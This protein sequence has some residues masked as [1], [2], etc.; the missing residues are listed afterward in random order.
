MFKA[1]I[2]ADIVHS[3]KLSNADRVYLLG[4]LSKE[5]NRLDKK[6][7]AKSELYRGDSIQ[8]VVFDVW[9]ALR[10][11]LLIKFF[12]RSLSPAERVKIVTKD[13]KAVNKLK[14][15][16]MLDVR[17]AIGIGEVSFINKKVITSDGEAFQISG[18]LLDK[19]KQGKQKLAIDSAD[20]NSEELKIESILLDVILDRTTALQSEVMYHKLMNM[21]E[22]QIAEK[23][24]INQ[25]AVNQRSSSGYWNVVAEM[26][27][28]FESKYKNQE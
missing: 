13:A 23:L 7:N 4:A 8:V 19:M 15:L 2:T 25:S 16:W 27:H 28:Y 5:L 3:R 26:V 24:G 14:A 22:V 21:T 20:S 18:M 11:A 12:I 10:V 17:M 9:N 6:F 1:V